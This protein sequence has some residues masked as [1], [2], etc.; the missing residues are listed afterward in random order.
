M[1]RTDRDS[2][3]RNHNARLRPS[4]SPL[5]VSPSSGRSQEARSSWPEFQPPNRLIFGQQSL[6]AIC[7]AS[8][9]LPRF[10]SRSFASGHNGVEPGS[11]QASLMLVPETR[12]PRGSS[13]LCSSP[14]RCQ[15]ARTWCSNY[16]AIQHH[17]TADEASACSTIVPSQ[18]P[19]AQPITCQKSSF[20]ISS[21]ARRIS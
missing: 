16:A 17:T 9:N 3:P 8:G 20:T 12:P 15:E 18:S 2:R 21:S 11:R 13:P 19:H 1:G 10:P 4:R 6:S 5:W 7:S 14:L